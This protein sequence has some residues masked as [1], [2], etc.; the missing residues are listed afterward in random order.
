MKILVINTGSSS[1]KYRLFQ[2]STEKILASGSVERIG[3]IKSRHSHEVV[4]SSGK[5][6]KRLDK[7]TID[8]H[9]QGF[10]KIVNCLNDKKNGIMENRSEIAAIGHRVVHGGESFQAPTIID[11]TVISAIQDN[12]PLAPLHNPSNLIGIEVMRSLFPDTPQ[13]AVFDTAFHKS[14]PKKAFLYALPYWLYKEH[15]VRRYGFHGTSHYYVAEMSARY[16]S[17]PLEELNL[18]TI[19]LGNG[20]SMAAIQ[21]GKCVDTTMGMTPMEGLV[22]GT[23]SGDIDPALPIFMTENLN[24]DIKVIHELLNRESGL[25]GICNVNDMREILKQKTVGIELAK[26]AIEV[27]VYRIKKY[28]GA[29][30]AILGNLNGLIFT[31]GIGENSPEIREMVCQDLSSLGI[32]I[33]NVKNNQYTE[34]I[35]DISSSEGKVR[36]LVVPTNEELKIAQE[37]KKIIENNDKHE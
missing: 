1:I 22:M 3:E 25:K 12:I 23:R 37:T 18:I 2:M 5:I 14:I 31:A 30:A 16:F 26:I 24:M 29:Y 32:C 13:V 35:R 34:G 6:F 20:A 4:S 21:N 17:R 15:R 28:I 7:E 10:Q 27:Y 36:I 9:S 33:D 11:E 8:N 19:H